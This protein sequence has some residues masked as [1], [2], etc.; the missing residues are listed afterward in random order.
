M[1]QLQIG[2]ISEVN[3]KKAL[4]KV[5]VDS[6]VTDWLPVLSQATK[7]KQHF[8]PLSVDDQVLVLNPHGNN[9]NGFV[10]SGIYSKKIKT[11]SQITD[12]C[13]AI[14]Y[15]DGT[16]IIYDSD[17]KKITIDTP[18]VIEVKAKKLI[19]KCDVKIEGNLEVTKSIKDKKGDLT[20]H[21]HEVSG[22]KLAKPR[23]GA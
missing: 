5:V 7:F 1:N 19:I 2:K 3:N 18:H 23:V 6:R 17:A 4:A 10:L 16:K 13:E 22:H 14:I 21:V 12:K 11:P 9:E 15:A 20:E 8:S